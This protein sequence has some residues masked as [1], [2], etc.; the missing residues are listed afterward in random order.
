MYQCIDFFCILYVGAN[1]LSR[2]LSMLVRILDHSST[3]QKMRN[4][5]EREKHKGLSDV[6]HKM[7]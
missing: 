5:A 2:A 6:G 3:I 7:C 1:I 4:T